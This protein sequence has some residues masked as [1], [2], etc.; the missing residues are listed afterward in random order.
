MKI[1]P[2]PLLKKIKDEAFIL[3]NY[4]ISASIAKALGN[5]LH[6]L[7]RHLNRIS[8]VKNNLKDLDL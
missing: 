1:L 3:D 2:L 8:L 5:T 4:Q 6:Y 7:G